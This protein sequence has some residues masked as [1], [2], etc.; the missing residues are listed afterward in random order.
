MR[1]EKIAKVK[2]TRLGQEDHGIFTAS[3]DLDYGGSGQGIPHYDL[4]ECAAQF[5][6]GILRAC[7]VDEWEKVAGRTILAVVE[8]GWVVG[9][10]PLPTEPGKPFMFADAYPT[11]TP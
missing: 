9:I 10:K 4:R 2:R 1:E 7:A 8:D 3:L 6:E 11:V 5:I